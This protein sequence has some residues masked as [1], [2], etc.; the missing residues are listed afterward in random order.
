MRTLL[1]TL[2]YDGSAYCGWQWQPNGVSLQQLVED[3][4]SEFVGEKTRITAAGRTDAGVHAVGQLVSVHTAS[5]IPVEGFRFGLA[6]KLPAD[7]V[8]RD[9][10]EMPYG[11]SARFDAVKKRYRY[12]IHTSRTPWPWLKNYVWWHRGAL[13]DAAMQAAADVL[14]GTHD[15]ACF[16]SQWPNKET[17]V[18]T[19]FEARWWRCT[20]WSAWGPVSGTLLSVP[21]TFCSLP[22]PSTLNPQ[23]FLCFDIVA[24]GF[25]YNMVRAIVGTLVHVGRGRW[26]ADDVRRILDAGDRSHAGDT[27]PPQGLYLVDVETRVDPQRIAAR[28]ERWQRRSASPSAR[29]TGDEEASSAE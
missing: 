6:T 25:L 24:D 15:F 8:I 19:V 21:D 26:T 17:S 1:L 28:L 23:P 2:A 4:L 20:E 5:E 13:D 12:V 16:E 11:F 10:V 22:Q 9:V 18:R 7:I 29:D 27:A 14:V 3:A